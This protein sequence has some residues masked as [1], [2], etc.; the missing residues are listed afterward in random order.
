MD[1]EKKVSLSYLN[2][3]GFGSDNFS[4]MIVSVLL[5]VCVIMVVQRSLSLHLVEVVR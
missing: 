5:E 4:S 1:F 2:C 3:L